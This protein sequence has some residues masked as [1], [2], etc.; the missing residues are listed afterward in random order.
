MSFLLGQLPNQQTCLHC[1]IIMKCQ[2]LGGAPEDR[3][4]LLQVT[5]CTW[6]YR[7]QR[8]V[9]RVCL[10][11][12]TTHLYNLNMENI[13]KLKG[14]LHDPSAVCIICIQ[15]TAERCKCENQYFSTQHH[16]LLTQLFVVVSSK[17]ILSLGQNESFY[18]YQLVLAVNHP[19]VFFI[20]NSL[21]EVLYL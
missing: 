3:E 16:Q 7:G 14:L 4:R 8:S 9:P 1:W 20:V 2:S 11:S 18:F 6:A 17:S 13:R 19:Q 5:A 21:L 10:L 15:Y 12:L